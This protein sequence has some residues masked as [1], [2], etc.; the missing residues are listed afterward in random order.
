MCVKAPQGERGP[1]AENE[2]VCRKTIPGKRESETE[3]ESVCRKTLQGR[4]GPD[5]KQELNA[6]RPRIKRLGHQ[7]GAATYKGALNLVA[8][9]KTNNWDQRLS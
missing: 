9:R 6:S 4:R 2:L 5:A 1:N 7:G 3:Q 8:T